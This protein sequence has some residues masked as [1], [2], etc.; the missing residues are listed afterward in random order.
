VSLQQN[1]IAALRLIDSAP[2]LQV[3]VRD[4]PRTT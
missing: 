2:R 4:S 1:L 3:A